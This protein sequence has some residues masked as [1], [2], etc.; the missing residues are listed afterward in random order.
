MNKR[1]I[2]VLAVIVVFFAAVY[3]GTKIGSGEDNVIADEIT[4]SEEEVNNITNEETLSTS[5]DE[6]KVTPN[7]LL[8]LKKY[9]S[10]CG[11]TIVNSAEIPEEMVNMTEE[12]VRKAY[13]NWDLEKF[14]KE[15]IILSKELESFCGEHYLLIEEEGRVFLYELDEA[16]NRN[17][18][19]LTDIVFEYLPETDKILLSKGIYVYGEEELGK[20]KEDFES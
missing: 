16:G 19:E 1:A 15:E 4:L 8:I 18:G 7:T 20:I 13:S 11:H 10:D 6:I 9:Y 2:F 5:T 17:E 12:E 14:T 3:F